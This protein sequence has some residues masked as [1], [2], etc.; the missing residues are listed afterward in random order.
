MET[1]RE[2]ILVWELLKLEQSEWWQ[3]IVRVHKHEKQAL[4]DGIM[5]IDP[6]R[7]E[8]CYSLNDM[9]KL[10]ITY[11]NWL[12]NAPQALKNDLEPMIKT[13]TPNL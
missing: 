5:T 12:L 10:I 9:D 4:I 7:D 8:K 2:Q 1:T 3:E 11:I 13:D 6:S